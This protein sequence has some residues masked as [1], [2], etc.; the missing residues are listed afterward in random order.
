MYIILEG[1]PFVLSRNCFRIQKLDLFEIA[2]ASSQK[3][4]LRRRSS[5]RDASFR[6]AKRF[7]CLFSFEPSISKLRIIEPS[8]ERP[9]YAR[10]KSSTHPPLP[11]AFL[12]RHSSHNYR[13]FKT[14]NWRVHSSH[15]LHSSH[16]KPIH[17]TSVIRT[18][19]LSN[20][21]AKR[22]VIPFCKRELHA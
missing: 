5:T 12:V 6:R 4:S 15:H 17:T 16:L 22:I 14:E 3:I 13:E 1:C 9:A 7:H 2:L 11:R 10:K 18:R 20:L 19:T 21:F 8:T